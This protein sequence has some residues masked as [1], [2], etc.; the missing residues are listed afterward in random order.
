MPSDSLPFQSWAHTLNVYMRLV[1]IVAEQ[2]LWRWDK[3]PLKLESV[4]RK[5]ASNSLQYLS[6]SRGDFQGVTEH[7][8]TLERS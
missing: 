8:F 6:L 2:P 1:C 3:V 5:Q 4:S 7:P